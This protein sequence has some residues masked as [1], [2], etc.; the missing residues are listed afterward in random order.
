[1]TILGTQNYLRLNL[2]HWSSDIGKGNGLFV[3]FLIRTNTI[4]SSRIVFC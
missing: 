3:G 1:M 4:T 2:F